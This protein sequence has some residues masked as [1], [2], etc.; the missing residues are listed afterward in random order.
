MAQGIRQAAREAAAARGVVPI[1]RPTV[2]SDTVSVACANLAGATVFYDA[3]SSAPN[4]GDLIEGYR[5]LDRFAIS[6][7]VR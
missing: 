6:P 3:P 1:N 5:A 4:F 7:S 2:S